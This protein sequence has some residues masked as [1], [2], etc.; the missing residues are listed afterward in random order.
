ML[1]N[2]NHLDSKINHPANVFNLIKYFSVLNII[3]YFQETPFPMVVMGALGILGG[4]CVLLLPETANKSLTSTP[5]E[6]R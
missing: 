5:Y 4:M 1:N 6:E 2:P 3:F